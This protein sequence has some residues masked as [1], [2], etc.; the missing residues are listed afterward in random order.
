MQCEQCKKEH[1]RRR[2][3]SNRCKDRWHN[4]HNARGIG[5]AMVVQDDRTLHEM[6]MDDC[7][8]GWDED[9]WISDDS[10]CTA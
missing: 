10:G 9:G 2:F 6:A 1:S 4:I 8:T 3:C 7:T 5:L